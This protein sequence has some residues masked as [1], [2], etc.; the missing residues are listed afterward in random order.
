M[1]TYLD[2]IPCFFRQAL[3]AAKLA[4][5]SSRTQRRVLN[6]LAGILPSFS[7]TSTPPE[8]GRIIYRM[9]SS[10]TGKKDPYARIKAESN[11][12]ALKL[13]PQLKK[14][15]ARSRDRLGAAVRLAIAGNIIDYGVKNSLNVERELEKMLSAEN[16]VIHQENGKLYQYE[17]FKRALRKAGTLL[18]LGDNAGETVFDRLLIEEI[19]REGPQKRISYAVKSGPTINDALEEDARFCGIDRAARIISNGLAAP[20]TILSLCSRSFLRVFH[21][22]DMVISKG[23]GNF[24]SLSFAPRPVFFLFMAKCPVVA[25][26]VGCRIGDVILQCG[27]K[28]LT[29]EG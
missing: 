2:C 1:K 25:K 14:K 7:L 3:E 21:Q 19:K 24:E 16:R 11:R 26:H 17:R 29:R 12:K 10:V 4:G 20:G 22:A 18:I 15:I 28:N 13:Y 27:G 23:Q 6:E 8:M 9:V 5:A